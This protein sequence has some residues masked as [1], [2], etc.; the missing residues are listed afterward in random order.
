MRGEIK[1]RQV[2]IASATIAVGAV[3]QTAF[4]CFGDD[5]NS[6]SNM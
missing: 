6:G 2:A 1:N 3:T 4:R 5:K